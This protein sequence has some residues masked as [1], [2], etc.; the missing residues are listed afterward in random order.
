MRN[1]FNNRTM[2]GTSSTNFIFNNIWNVFFL[3]TSITVV[4][5][6]NNKPFDQSITWLTACNYRVGLAKQLKVNLDCLSFASSL[7]RDC[8]TG[9]QRS[10]HHLTIGFKRDR[11]SCFRQLLFVA[12]E[13]LV[14]HRIL[15]STTE[16][17][18]FAISQ[19][20]KRNWNW[21]RE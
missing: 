15:I 11:S 2:T 14:F 9:V 1:C 13:G 3:K 19:N 7:S 10:P 18:D 5:K 20:N 21:R 17:N 16:R 6:S 8:D 12:I 4:L